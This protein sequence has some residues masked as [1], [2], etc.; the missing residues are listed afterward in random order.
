M[1]SNRPSKEL[2]GKRLLRLRQ[3]HGMSQPQLGAKLGTSRVTISG[4]ERGIFAPHGSNL[5]PLAEAFKLDLLAMWKTLYR[6]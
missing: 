4:W 3:K 5:L 1:K 2:V 6:R